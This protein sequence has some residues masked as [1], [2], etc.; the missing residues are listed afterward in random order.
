MGCLGGQI[1][2]V[3]GADDDDRP[4][5][6]NSDDKAC[7]WQPGSSSWEALPSM[8]TPRQ[9]AV[10]VAL[11]DG[12]VLVAGGF[13]TSGYEDINLASAEVLAADGS[14]WSAVAPMHTARY[15]AVGGLLPGGRVIVAGGSENDDDGENIL[16]TAEL[17]DPVTNVWTELPPMATARLHAAGSLCDTPP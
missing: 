11:G 2:V 6:V 8:S 7:R 5:V 9:D 1:T 13:K 3:G 12:K 4:I 10:A 16:A 14:S 17:W 15:G